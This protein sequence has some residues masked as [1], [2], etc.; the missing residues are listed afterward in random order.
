MMM[1]PEDCY[2]AVG[3]DVLTEAFVAADKVPN[4]SRSMQGARMLD[5]PFAEWAPRL[6]AERSCKPLAL[7]VH[8]PFCRHRCLFCPFY[9]NRSNDTFSAWY[10]DL[11]M[12]HLELVEDALGKGSACRPVDAVFFGGG[13]PSDLNAP[14]LARVL[15]RLKSLFAISDETEVTI[16][17]R[18]RDFTPDK[19][20]AWRDA[21]ANRFSLGI[22]ST[23]EALRRRLGRLAGR[24]EMLK[25]LG[26]L[27]DSGAVLIVD[28][29]FGLPGQTPELLREDLR[30]LAEETRIDGLDLYEL[31]QFP[32]SPLTKA[33]E[34]G[35]LGAPLGRAERARMFGAAHEA[36]AGYGFEHFTP[37]HWRR[38]SRERS[39]YNRLAKS[40]A[41]I[42]PIG[43]SAGGNLSR[44]SMMMERNIDTYAEKINEG[45]IP[46]RCL[47]PTAPM[48]DEERFKTRLAEAAERCEL[49]PLSR[50]PQQAHAWAAPLLENWMEVGLIKSPVDQDGA[51]ALTVAGAYWIKIIQR[52]L[53]ACLTPMHAESSNGYPGGHRGGAH[54]HPGGGHP[55]GNRPAG[56]GA[57][58]GQHSSHAG[59]RG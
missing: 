47:A 25:V 41:D 57:G 6:F 35:R 42:L 51:F 29:I 9:Q 4:H 30:F 55:Q 52:M 58:V 49:P 1:K 24:E 48:S 19:V 2:V 11:L 22:Q 45:I 16:E 34:S 17:G 12:R 21:G 32:N 23:D 56:S 50:W 36:L 27:A 5:K 20:K 13:T 33:V 43:S 39:V 26:S 15:R 7:Y 38:G 44:V 37:Q 31:I 53:M 14:D 54:G 3:A 8:V 40:N 59:T 28:L 10:A 46:A 18:I